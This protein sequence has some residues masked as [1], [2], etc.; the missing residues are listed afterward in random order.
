M[1]NIYRLFIEKKNGFDVEAA[2]LYN[3]LI[4]LLEIKELKKLRMLYRYDVQGVTDDEYIEARDS[5][6]SDPPQD[7]VYEETFP[8]ENNDTVFSIEFLPGQYDQ[9]SD[10]AA[11]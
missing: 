11:Q 8:H 2:N 4:R 7:I 9:R 10:S 3:D 6:F 5:V 1:E